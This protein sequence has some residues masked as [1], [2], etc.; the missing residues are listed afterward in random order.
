MDFLKIDGG[1]VRNL[2]T[3]P[4][5]AALVGSIHEI[6]RVLGLRTIAESVE[7]QVTLDAVRRI[8]VDY[9]QGFYVARP[10]PLVAAL[11]QPSATPKP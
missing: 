5:Q 3:D 2:T 4:I 6:G 9:A 7:D 8:G 11:R 10:E 1:F